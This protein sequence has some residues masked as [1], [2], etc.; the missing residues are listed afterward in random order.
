MSPTHHSDDTDDSP[1]LLLDVECWQARMRARGFTTVTAQAVEAELS[2]S[3]L[4]DL[5]KGRAVV[6][7]KVVRQ[8]ARAADAKPSQVFKVADQ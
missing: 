4:T 7:P 5:L 8:V 2:R 6:R 3:H 1:V